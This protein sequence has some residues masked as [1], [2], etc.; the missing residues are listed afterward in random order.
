MTSLGIGVLRAWAK[1]RS[2]QTARS[3]RPGR[4][5][6]ILG[7]GA[8]QPPSQPVYTAAALSLSSLPPAFPSGRGPYTG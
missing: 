1:P 2:L 5:D 4:A 6:F 8:Q 7:R 3:K